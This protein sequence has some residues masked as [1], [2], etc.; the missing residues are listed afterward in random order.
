MQSL[1]IESYINLLTSIASVINR[2][3]FCDFTNMAQ[4]LPDCTKDDVHVEDLI[5]V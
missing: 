5:D 4:Y 1:M 2:I 3:S